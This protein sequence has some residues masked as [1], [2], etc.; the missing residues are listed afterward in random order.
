MSIHTARL[1]AEC[2]V[3]RL[4]GQVRP[5][6]IK[7]IPRRWECIAVP[8]RRREGARQARPARALLL[9]ACTR[10]S[11]F[12]P[13]PSDRLARQGGGSWLFILHRRGMGVDTGLSPKRLFVARYPYDHPDAW[14]TETTRQSTGA[15]VPISASLRSHSPAAGSMSMLVNSS[16]LSHWA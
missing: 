3:R 13:A 6:T 9:N 15:G 5:D 4:T 16:W 14:W 1:H 2:S 8:V 10:S 11:A 7:A 12:L